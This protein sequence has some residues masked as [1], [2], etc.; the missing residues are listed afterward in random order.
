MEGDLT[1][2][3]LLQ[4]PNS[5]SEHLRYV[6]CPTIPRRQTQ[7]FHDKNLKRTLKEI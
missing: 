6:T 4:R 7:A 1:W 5:S 2:I 3:K